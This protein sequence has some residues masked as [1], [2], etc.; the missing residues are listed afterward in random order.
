MMR[1]HEID[2]DAD[3]PVLDV[4]VGGKLV[5]ETVGISSGMDQPAAD[6]SIAEIDPTNNHPEVYFTSYSG[7]AHCCSTVIVADEVGDKWVPVEIGDFDGGGDFLDDLDGDG[8][9][10]IS[11]V[12][13]RFLYQFSG[14]AGSAA[15]LVIYTV[16]GG[17]KIDVTTEPRF[18]DAHRDWLKQLE[19]SI[20]PASR[21]SEPGFLAGWL[22]EKVRLGEGAEAWKELNQH[23]DLKNDEGEEVCLTGG[24]PEDCPKKNRAVLKFPERLKLFLDQNGY[25]T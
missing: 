16:R 4:T 10:E 25:G 5:L 13:N 20:D 3:V 23:W 6:A 12:D 2:P 9:A 21:W 19:D 7:G 1:R 14:Y 22:A 8:L 15:P 17:K 18:H 24:E 11:T